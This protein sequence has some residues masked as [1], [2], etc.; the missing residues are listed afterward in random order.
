M[1][2]CVRACCVCAWC[3]SLGCEAGAAA[4]RLTLTRRP[5]DGGS[6]RRHMR[7]G[8]MSG[9]RREKRWDEKSERYIGKGGGISLMHDDEIQDITVSCLVY[10]HFLWSIS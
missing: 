7:Q 3:V 2:V 1:C 6:I 8:E 5:F 10:S 9:E 4:G